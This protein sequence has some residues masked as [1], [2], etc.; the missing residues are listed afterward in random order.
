MSEVRD[1]LVLEPLRETNSMMIQSEVPN[2]SKRRKVF[3]RSLESNGS[4]LQESGGDGKD[5]VT[6]PRSVTSTNR[7]SVEDSSPL[8]G[9]QRRARKSPSDAKSADRLSLFGSTFGGTIGKSRKPPPRYSAGYVF[10]DFT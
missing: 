5:T 2:N 4:L 7:G 3:G 8:P 6:T 10:I 9:P 1:I